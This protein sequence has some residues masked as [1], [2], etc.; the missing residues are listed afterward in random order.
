M[1][2]SSLHVPHLSLCVRLGS[3]PKV[4]H[5][6]RNEAF[7]LTPFMDEPLSSRLRV[8][9]TRPSRPRSQ[10]RCPVR[11]DYFGPPE[12]Q[13]RLS[14]R[15]DMAMEYISPGD[16]DG[17]GAVG[18]L[19]T[20]EP[21]VVEGRPAASANRYRTVAVARGTLAVT[22]ASRT[23]TPRDGAGAGPSAADLDRLFDESAAAQAASLA[24]AGAT[25][26]RPP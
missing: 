5:I 7:F 4:G 20:E 19:D 1:S 2:T 17:T 13:E 3:L 14:A 21:A 10:F 18:T 11:T 23:S 15:L 24:T 26:C 6:S 9:A 25:L 16:C 12:R 8:L 22:V